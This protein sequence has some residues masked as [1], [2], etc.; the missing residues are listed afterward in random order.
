MAD[1]E[2]QYILDRLVE[3]HRPRTA[4]PGGNRFRMQAGDVQGF[5]RVDVPEPSKKALI[6]EQRLEGASSGLEGQPKRIE[7][8]EERVRTEPGHSDGKFGGPFDAAEL[9]GVVVDQLA[10][11]EVEDR[12]GVGGG[13]AVKQQLTRHAEMDY[14]HSRIKF[15]DNELAVTADLPDG[16]AG[17]AGGQSV[18]IARGDEPR[19]ESCRFDSPALQRT[20]KGT[21]YGL[22]F[23][24]FGHL[25]DRAGGG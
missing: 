9:A 19:R 13:C 16:A 23:G 1:C 17:E 22:D 4:E 8:D 20:R 25:L 15:E 10:P 21:N 7:G 12:T 6:Q 5:V 24:K 14:Q 18:P 11:V 2:P 3:P